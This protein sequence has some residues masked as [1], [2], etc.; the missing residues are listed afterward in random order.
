MLFGNIVSV[1]FV[2]GW[3]KNDIWNIKTGRD[4]SLPFLYLCRKAREGN[5]PV[6]DF[7]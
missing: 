5:M 1:Q 3:M 4:G 7:R 2:R 6:P